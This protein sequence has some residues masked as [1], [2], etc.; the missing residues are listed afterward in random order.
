MQNT[1]DFSAG[2]KIFMQIITSDKFTTKICSKVIDN[3][4]KFAMQKIFRAEEKNT[5]EMCTS[6]QKYIKKKMIQL[7]KLQSI[8]RKLCSFGC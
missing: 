4:K 1:K 3:G 8:E 5:Q 6:Q 7:A 2:Q